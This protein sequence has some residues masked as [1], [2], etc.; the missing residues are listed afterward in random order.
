[1]SSITASKFD[2]ARAYVTIDAH[3]VG[4]M[5]VYVYKTENYGKDWTLITDDNI[6]GYSHKIIE[7]L[8]NENLLF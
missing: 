2:K 5:G 1:M 6:E 8:E 3:R 7:D 4:N